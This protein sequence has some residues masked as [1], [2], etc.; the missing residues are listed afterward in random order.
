MV[1]VILDGAIALVGSGEF[2]AAMEDVDRALLE[3]RTRKVAHLATA[4]APE[5]EQRLAYWAGLAAVH[6]ERLGAEVDTVPI[7]DRETADDPAL[8]RRLAGAGLV[9]LSGGNPAYLADSL[10]GSRAW[11]AIVA[12]HRVGIPVAGCSA[13]AAALTAVAPDMRTLEMR[14]GLGLV[15]GLAVIP[16]FD[17]MRRWWPEAEAAHLAHSPDGIAVVGIDED[18]AIVGARHRWWVRGR[19]TATRLRPGAPETFAT[20]DDF[21]T[22]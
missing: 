13:G 8:V 7:V 4:A 15:P 18:T 22:G 14:P 5:G 11:Q 17:R 1:T 6:Y 16:H 21:R 20:G 3:G 19:G 9:Y 2:T 12:S 10:R